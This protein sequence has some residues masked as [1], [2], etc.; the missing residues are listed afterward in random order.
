MILKNHPKLLHKNVSKF[1]KWHPYFFLSVLITKCKRYWLLQ[2]TFCFCLTAVSIFPLFCCSFPYTPLNMRKQ[3]C[4]FCQVVK[5][6][7]SHRQKN[8]WVQPHPP[9]LF[10]F[11][12]LPLSLPSPRLPPPTPVFVCLLLF[13]RGCHPTTC[14]RCSW[15]VDC[16][17]W[18]RAKCRAC[19]SFTSPQ[20]ALSC[21]CSVCSRGMSK[22]CLCLLYLALQHEHLKDI[23]GLSVSTQL[24]DLPD[25]D[26]KGIKHSLNLSIVVLF[27]LRFF[28]PVLCV[29]PAESPAARTK[30]IITTT[31]SEDI[32]GITWKNS[33]LN[34]KY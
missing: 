19:K 32:V 5:T 18:G 11:F 1:Q 30:L 4:F 9:S 16:L 31:A 20:P 6:L 13:L 10:L 14:F 25:K 28:L 17:W 27:L 33:N 8:S 24:Q 29:W 21:Q 22:I 3:C 2:A 12:P 34:A 26:L 23:K 7:L 15:L